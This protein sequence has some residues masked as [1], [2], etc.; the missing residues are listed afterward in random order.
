MK[1]F[2]V[3]LL[4]FAFSLIPALD[5]ST[6]P[7]YFN[8]GIN[9]ELV[10]IIKTSNSTWIPYEASENPF[11]NYT[12]KELKFVMS[13]PGI[14]Y[15]KYRQKFKKR[16][17]D[18]NGRFLINSDITSPTKASSIP[19]TFDWRTTTDGQRC[20]PPVQSQGKCGACYAFASISTFSA[21]YC[22]LVPS[23]TAAAYSPQDSLACNIR[24]EACNGGIL[25]Y[26]FIYMEEYGVTTLACQPY[27]E[28]QTSDTSTV[29]SQKCLATTCASGSPV[30]KKFCKKGTSVILEGTERIKYEIM[31]KG[32]VAS[33]MM[34]YEDLMS[35]KSGIY[36]HVTGTLQGGH[37]IV[38]VGWGLEGTTE[39][40]IVMNSWGTSWGL[41]G[42]FK[43]D[44]SD[45]NSYPDE[46]A[47]Y[48]VPEAS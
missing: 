5:P 25:D 19:S 30:I 6:L 48:C 3:L 22:A 18:I 31:T 20:M 41:S 12:D 17:R 32:P 39:Y 10:N 35:Y 9:S 24:T 44:M 8:R 29:P 33:S 1:S 11:R 46:V 42:Y 13:M 38:L 7:H 36:K 15:E 2:A 34:T 37:A 23:E 28:Y 26:A 16:N 14:D 27:A 40:W 43:L 45:L 21:R 4:T 47:F